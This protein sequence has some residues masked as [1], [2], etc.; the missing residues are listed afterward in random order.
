MPSHSGSCHCGAITFTANADLSKGT[1]RCNCTYCRK[2]RNWI[3][4][5]KP[6]DV[7][8]THGQDQIATYKGSMGGNYTSCPTCGIRLWT[9]GHHP[10][11]GDFLNL[12]VPTLDDLDPADLT[13]A[14]VTWIDGAQDDWQNPPAQTAHL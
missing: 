1:H 14:S 13:A 3:V 5:L 8:V 11:F 6:Q 10:A 4:M 7:S 12:F 9:S 2:S